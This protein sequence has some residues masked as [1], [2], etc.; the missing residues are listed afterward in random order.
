M[1]VHELIYDPDYWIKNA[2]AHDSAGAEINPRSERAR[3]WCLLGA[4][5]KCYF[6]ATTREYVYK[7][8]AD[9]IRKIT[10]DRFESDYA[11]GIITHWNDARERTHK[12]V[13]D[14]ALSL[15]V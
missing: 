12:E 10:G 1:K 15:D 8:F 6:D 2:D 4:I 14:L 13:Y 11:E 7:K 9:R 3:C 5:K